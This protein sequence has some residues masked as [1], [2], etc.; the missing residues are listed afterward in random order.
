MLQLK[1]FETPSLR[2][3]LKTAKDNLLE[4]QQNLETMRTNYNSLQE[5]MVAK[6]NFFTA[7]QL[8]LKESNAREIEKS[9]LCTKKNIGQFVNLVKCNI[10]T[11]LCNFLFVSLC[12]S[13]ALGEMW[14]LVK[15]S[16]F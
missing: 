13:S 1:A 14:R 16:L 10:S 5:E 3:A 6:E 4:S 7:H 9:E 12:V 15:L 2:A 8:T 11:N